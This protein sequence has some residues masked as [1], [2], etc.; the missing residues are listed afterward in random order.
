MEKKIILLSD[1]TGNSAASPHKTNVWRTYKALDLSEA[2]GQVAFYDNGVGTSRFTPTALLGLAFGWGLARNVREIYG[3]LCRE[4]DPGATVY[5][6]GFSRGAFTMRVVM[7]L[8]ASEGII[9]VEGKSNRELERLIKRAYRRFREENFDRSFLS[10]FMGPLWR[11]TVDLND[12]VFDRAPYRPEENFP[13]SDPATGE[14]VIKFLGV[15]DTVDAYGLPVDE[16]TRAWDRVVWPLSAKDRN[17]SPNIERACHALAIDEQRESFEPML[18]NEDGDKVDHDR[19]KQV[20]FAG[21]HADVGGSYPD[22]ALSFIPLN[23]MLDESGLL[24]LEAVREAYRNRGAARALGHDSRSG[25]GMLYRYAPRHIE[26]LNQEK[27]PG[28]WNWLKKKFGCKDFVENE[29]NITRPKIHHSVFERIAGGGRAY[30]PINIPAD[31]DL[32]DPSESGGDGTPGTDEDSGRRERPDEAQTRRMRQT[33]LWKKV[34]ARKLLYFA[35]LGLGV[36][37]ILFPYISPAETWGADEWLETVLAPLVGTLGGA[38]RALPE[39]VG[40]IPMLGFAE[41]WAQDYEAHPYVF[42]IG[43][44][45]IGVLIFLSL[46]VKV[47]IASDMRRNWHHLHGKGNPRS[48]KPDLSKEKLARF[49]DSSLYKDK[50][51]KGIRIATESLA[52]LLLLYLILALFSRS[53]FVVADG[54]GGICETDSTKPNSQ[55]KEAFEFNS[56]ETCMSTG[57]E[58]TQGHEYHIRIEILD[59]WRDESIEAD[60]NGWLTTPL[61][62]R[63]AT[64]LRRHLFAGWYQPVARIDNAFYDRYPLQGECPQEKGATEAA[65]PGAKQTRLCMTFRARRTGEL[66]LYLN[67]AVL[68]APGFPIEFYSNN[69]GKAQVT[70]TKVGS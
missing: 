64:P 37:F 53:F 20:W 3:F 25:F 15:W 45:V 14:K 11:W 7:A 5:G 4:Y 22:D 69:E 10:S 48:D 56:Y 29:V 51:V 13:S 2:S 19:L 32:V 26:R 43:I 34:W 63:L 70:V 52:I 8:I 18:W 66:Y 46:K 67:D 58:L 47:R 30:A 50:V 68:F 9:P 59:V 28:L 40:K 27:K 57:L 54:L 36:F 42:L 12:K 55:F 6:F 49:L 65:A 24:C 44:A 39:L 17:L 62:L 41:T 21:V 31:Y 38:V 61:K 23:W 1:G 35:T 60:V 33:I 16:L